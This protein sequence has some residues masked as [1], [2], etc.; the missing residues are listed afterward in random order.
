MATKMMPVTWGILEKEIQGVELKR[1]AWE[2]EE[3]AEA[4]QPLEQEGLE[5]NLHEACT[6]SIYDAS[7]RAIITYMYPTM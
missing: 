7:L 1:T 5:Q 6:K 3:R 4:N 2:L